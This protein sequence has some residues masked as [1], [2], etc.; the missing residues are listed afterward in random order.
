MK[1]RLLTPLSGMTLAILLALTVG[2]ALMVGPEARAAGGGTLEGN[3][4]MESTLV[5]CAT[6][7]PLPIPGNPFPALHTYMR[8]GTVL[9]S[10][11]SP[12]AALGGTRS[13]AHD[14]WKR[15]GTQTF[16]ERF[17]SFSFDADGVHMSTAEVT[18]ER[19]LLPGAQAEMD[20]IIG[21]GTP[22]SLLPLAISLEKGAS[23][24]E[25]NATHSKSQSKAGRAHT[26]NNPKTK[27]RQGRL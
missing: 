27:G 17:H 25:G 14:I 18:F 11:A 15:T 23:R 9:D 4:L 22:S 12:P 19:S 6:G 2:Q 24:I 1:T 8:G 5:N 21:T 7:D 10:G 13:S 26:R 16:R 20:E 3:W